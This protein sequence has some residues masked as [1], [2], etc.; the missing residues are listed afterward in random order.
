[1][2]S[3]LIATILPLRCAGEISAMYIGESIDA[4][5]TPRPA[6][7]LAAI[8]KSREGAKAIAS[9]EPAKIKAAN[10]KPGRRPY[11]SATVPAIRQP[12][13]APNAK[14]PVANPSQ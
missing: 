14:L 13:M 12:N 9:D 4:I 10:N 11:L 6:Q 2:V 3:W 5:P 7:H 8:N 1:M